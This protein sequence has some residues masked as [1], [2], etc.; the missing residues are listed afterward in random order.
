MY[1][2]IIIEHFMHPKN[3]GRLENPTNIG[4]YETPSMAK[5]VFYFLVEDGIVKDIKYQ[6]AGC[7]FA[8]AVG[9]II[10]EYSRGKSVSELEKI[11][12]KFLERYFTVGEDKE[13]CINL[14]LIAFLNG[15]SK[16]EK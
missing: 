10:S 1:P 9:S 13:G 6:I 5:A 7:P 14:T 11:D 16:S 4:T 2:K 15:I 3:V 12:K 8:I